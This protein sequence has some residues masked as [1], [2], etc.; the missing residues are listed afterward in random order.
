MVMTNRHYVLTQRDS[1]NFKGKKR[2]S[3][4]FR[5]R[6]CDFD[7]WAVLCFKKKP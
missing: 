6:L 7:F 3:R 2:K 5:N 1:E 4:F